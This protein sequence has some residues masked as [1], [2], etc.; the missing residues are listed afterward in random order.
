LKIRRGRTSAYQKG[1]KKNYYIPLVKHLITPLLE[2]YKNLESS[3]PLKPQCQFSKN[4]VIELIGKLRSL[5]FPGYFDSY[6][7]SELLEAAQILL[8]KQIPLPETAEKFLARLPSIRASLATDVEAAF[9]GDPAAT[10]KEEIIIA[11]PG[12]YAVS[13]YRLA[14]ELH[15]L[16]VPMLPR[17][18]TEYAH[19]ITGIDIHPGAQIGNYFFIDHGT[20]IV[21]GETTI[22]GEHVKIYQG[23]TL[24]ALST[25]GGQTLKGQKR[26]P[27]VEDNVTIYSGASIFGGET[28]IGKDS[29]LGS[30]V[31]VTS[32]VPANSK[33]SIN[34]EQQF[35]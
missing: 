29:V 4:D 14:H 30:N 25:R 34:N 9:S 3:I 31:F 19:S 24:G 13:I 2:S 32:S 27:T 20:G 16:K 33:L 26:H 28:V 10:G 6:S 21:I 5:L 11:Y 35:Y 12:F 22:I 8:N 1:G 18:M 7:T 17:A 15:L 23:V